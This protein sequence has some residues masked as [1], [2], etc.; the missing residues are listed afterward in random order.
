[1]QADLFYC[2]DA[3][4][5]LPIALVSKTHYLEHVD[6]LSAFEK[7]CLTM[8][9]FKGGLGE[10]A[11]IC[12]SDGMLVKAYVGMGDD[13]QAK[14]IACAVTRLPPGNYHV[15]QPLSKT[16]QL[17]W[18]LAQYQFDQYK[19]PKALPRVLLIGKE[20]FSSLLAEASAVFL[21][22]DLINR[23]ANDLG[24]VQ[25]AEVLS[26]LANEYG[27]E[28][29][30]WVGDKLL[31]NN[32]PAIYE[33]GRAAAQEPRLLSL[34]WGNVNHPRVTL[35]G[36]GVCFDTGGLDI[37]PSTAMRLMKKDMGGAAQVIGLARWLMSLKLP[38]RLQVLIPAIEN[39][40][41]AHSYR[42]GD[43]LTMRNGLKVEVD[44]T[45]AEGRLVLADALVKACEDKPEVLFNFATL[46]GAAR[47][48]V[49]TEMAAMFTN[50]DALAQA[51]ITA[52]EEVE[53]PV[54]RM[55]LFAAYASMLDSAIAD[56]ANG[57]ASPYA[58]AITAALFLQHFID[59]EIPWAHFDIMAW[60]VA[61]KPGK[62]EGGEAMGMRAVAHYLL[63][64]YG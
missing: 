64:R 1:M 57:S 33:V 28:F 4:K 36:K 8:Q 40:V 39:S 52:A 55:P 47:V 30:Q 18:S 19:T 26:D 35:V 60:N 6:G 3:E 21:V 49:G 46:T 32:F 63:H 48:A 53:D 38:I 27:A 59:A 16:A 22:R 37:K 20:I 45:D 51:I 14:A 43:V 9:Q 56:L 62:P 25:L 29:Q 11:M 42:P 17:A 12:E 31:T 61:N 2:T 7:N 5:S 50:S 41:S 24:P 15:Q 58:G 44:N 34:L 23:P 10:V 13:S 54:W